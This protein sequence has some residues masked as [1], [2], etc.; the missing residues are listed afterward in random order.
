MH[1]TLALGVG[2]RVSAFI[3]VVIEL[4][5]AAGSRFAMFA[6]VRGE[7]LAY[8]R[9]FVL[10]GK[11]VVQRLV[12]LIR[13]A[14]ADPALDLLRRLLLH[15][16]GDVA[17]NINRR[18]RRNM[19]DDGGERFHVHAVL[20]GGGCKGMAQVVEADV[21]AL[22]P[23]QYFFHLSIDA[24]RIQRSVF[25]YGRG[26]HPPRV[27]PF[28]Q[29]PQHV[30]H[31]RRQNDDPIRAFRLRRRLVQCA[32]DVNH[33]PLNMELTGAQ[34]QIVS[35]QRADLAAPHAGRQFQEHHLVEA[36]LLRLDQKPLHL[37]MRE[38]LHLPRLLRRQL[39]AD[40]G[41]HADQP[42]GFCLF[43]CDSAGG[44]TGAHHA[45]GQTGT[46]QFT[47]DAPPVP[48]QLRVELL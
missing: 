16:A 6:L 44:V 42:L 19:P 20:Q 21:L 39:A 10:G 33:L 43:Q 13:L 23:H 32:C 38:Y 25:F 18:S 1:F 27:R 28:F 12:G 4:V 17:V 11:L 2:G 45:V 30:H 8:R 14:V 37:F 34:I 9:F 46:K 36:V 40:G 31:G 41:I 5:D 47:A 35:L 15:G 22:R 24:L 29:F 48:L 7:R 3:E 26:E